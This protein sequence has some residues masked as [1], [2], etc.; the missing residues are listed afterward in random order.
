LAATVLVGAEI[1]GPV[2]LIIGLWPRFTAVLMVLVATIGIWTTQRSLGMEALFSPRQHVELYERLAVLG[3]LLLYFASG[4]GTGAERVC[5]DGTPEPWVP[6]S[7]CK[8][9]FS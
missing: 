4:P 3:G 6:R 8:A 2:A 5:A 1:L 7:Y 9:A